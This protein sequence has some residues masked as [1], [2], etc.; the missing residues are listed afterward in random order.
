MQYLSKTYKNT[1]KY[2][3]NV[4]SLQNY[5]TNVKIYMIIFIFFLNMYLSV[6]KTT[7]APGIHK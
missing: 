7:Q 2:V 5:M 3:Q 1:K 4:I 6:A